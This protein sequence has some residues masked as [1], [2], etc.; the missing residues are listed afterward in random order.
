MGGAGEG[1][2]ASAS[3]GMG[4]ESIATCR[5]NAR[6]Q[7]LQTV[8]TRPIYCFSRSTVL[9][10]LQ[11]NEGAF[12][13]WNAPPNEADGGWC[14]N[15]TVIP[16]G[17]IKRLLHLLKQTV[18]GT[19]NCATVLRGIAKRLL[20]SMM[21]M[22]A[23]TRKFTIVLLGVIRWLRFIRIQFYLDSKFSKPVDT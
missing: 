14:Y 22:A 11:T 4:R 1:G 20:H 19:T 2:A 9:H 16:R 8:L 5:T 7:W 21:Q 23:G 17:V 13:K 10:F 15:F 18:A 3:P 6:K 12:L